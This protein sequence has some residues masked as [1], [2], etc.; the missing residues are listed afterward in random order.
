AL[1][2]DAVQA[3]RAASPALRVGVVQPNL[4]VAHARDPRRLAGQLEGLQSATARLEAAGAELVVWPEGAYPYGVSR[5]ARQ[6][7]T[8]A[9][10]FGAR[11]P[12]LTGAITDAGRCARWNSVLSVA[13]D[14]ALLGVSDKVEL[15][16]FG[17]TVPLW[18]WL[19]P[20]QER[21]PCPGLRAGEAPGVLRAANARV[22]VLNCYED[23]LP[24]HARRVAQHAPDFLV[25]VT[26]D[27]WFGPSAEPHLHDAVA[28]LR[29]I[30]TR[31]DLVRA[32]NTGVSS[33]TAAT[34]ERLAA[35]EIFVATELQADVRRLAGVT[36]WV[37]FGDT[38]T[39]ALT[40]ALL[41]TAWT[42]R[43]RA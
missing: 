19:P 6:A 24:A 2:L 16:P 29:A 31:R 42:R 35:T 34:G 3:L 26:N 36:A 18:S 12:L 39:P 15:I 25:N 32:T 17:E 20:L 10:A 41:M 7:P 43:P 38:T 1:R 4:P 30:E 23:V 28:R 9:R 11:G 33:H 37:R 5:T 27:G 40:L 13:P 22:G 21:F 14:G 8:G